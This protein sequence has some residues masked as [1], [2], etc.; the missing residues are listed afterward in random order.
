MNRYLTKLLP[1][2]CLIFTLQSCIYIEDDGVWPDD[3]FESRTLD[4][5]EFDAVRAGDGI[6]VNINYGPT[7]KIVIT[8]KRN[9]VNDVKAK[10]E[11]GKLNIELKNRWFTISNNLELSITVPNIKSVELSG[12]VEGN[13]TNFENLDELFIGLSGA[14]DVEIISDIKSLKFDL[15]GASDLFIFGKG[16]YLDGKLSGASE[17]N[18]AGYPVKESILNLSGASQAHLH[19]SDKIYVNATGA[20]IVWCGGTAKATTDLSGGSAF[21]RQ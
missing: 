10:V 14:S 6:L 20:S 13:I 18:A 19:V 15:S 5:A 17:L 11:N 1:A 12:A 21:R 16:I 4:L 7:Q 3:I 2:L 8:G 9:I